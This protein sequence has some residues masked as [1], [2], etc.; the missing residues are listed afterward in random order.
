MGTKNAPGDFDCY[1]NA[2]PDEPIFV[3]LG[4]DLAAPDIVRRWAA[5]YLAQKRLDYTENG[6]RQYLPQKVWDKYSEALRCAVAMEQWRRENPP[7]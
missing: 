4:R 6:E 5:H 3:L 2:K 1:A 7:S